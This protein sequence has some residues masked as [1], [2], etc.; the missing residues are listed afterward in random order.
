MGRARDSHDH[1]RPVECRLWP[2]TR[3]GSF[4]GAFPSTTVSFGPFF[5]SQRRHS[6]K[7]LIV[8]SWSGSSRPLSDYQH[9]DSTA[10]ETSTQSPRSTPWTSISGGKAAATAARQSLCTIR[11]RSLGNWAFYP[12]NRNCHADAAGFASNKE[13]PRT[14]LPLN[15]ILVRPT[16]ATRP[17]EKGDVP[18][19]QTNPIHADKFRK[20]QSPRDF[21]HSALAFLLN[22]DASVDRC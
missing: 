4:R 6:T 14:L 18:G 17:A 1:V 20:M 15:K 13:V 12:A 5:K 2:D 16:K 9:R 19:G 22:L 8:R 11:G 21:R 10:S 3:R 7:T